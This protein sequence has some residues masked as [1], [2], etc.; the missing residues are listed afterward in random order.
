MTVNLSYN[1]DLARVLVAIS[2]VPNGTVKVERST[3]LLAWFPVRGGV[4]LPVVAGT[5]GLSDYEFSPDVENH[6][7]VT[8]TS[9]EDKVDFFTSSGTWSKPDGLVAVRVTV[10]G[11]GGAGGGSA[12]TGASQA[13]MGAGG[14]GGAC[15]I[16]WVDAASLGA[17]EEVVVGAGGVAVSG[18]AGGAGG[19][20]R[21]GSSGS[22]W[23]SAT[24]GT[25]GSTSSASSSAG[26]VMSSGATPTTVGDVGIPGEAGGNGRCLA[27]AALVEGG[28]GGSSALGHGGR[29]GAATSGTSAGSGGRLYGGGG[30][31]SAAVASQSATAGGNG[32]SGVVIV[33][34]IFAG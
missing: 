1:G 30:G 5:A 18:G 31:G 7:R 11:G 17:T 27:S 29:A 8:Q 12:A 22:P 16:H 6:Y 19:L 34:H 23:A 4:G 9:L 24:G 3:N 10:V 14:M 33:E 21:F 15:A 28:N 32:A 20:S 25:G 13:S 26:V 2:S